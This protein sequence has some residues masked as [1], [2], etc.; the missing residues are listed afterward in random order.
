MSNIHKRERGDESCDSSTIQKFARVQKEAVD[1]ERCW[2]VLTGCL[3]TSKIRSSVEK[4]DRE[5]KRC[6]ENERS[7]REIKR[8]KGGLLGDC[9]VNERVDTVWWMGDERARGRPKK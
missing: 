8:N 4:K 1:S 5:M 6:K 2:R 9:W 3:K 7:N